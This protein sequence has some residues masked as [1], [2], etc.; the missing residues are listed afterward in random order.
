MKQQRQPNS[1]SS[2]SRV[3][4]VLLLTIA[5]P[6]LLFSRCSAD[7]SS[8][9]I[10]DRHAAT[11]TGLK[12]K[13]LQ[14]SLKKINQKSIRQ[15]TLSNLFEADAPLAAAAARGSKSS[16][17]APTAAPREVTPAHSTADPSLQ[18]SLTP[19]DS[20]RPSSK[21]SLAPSVS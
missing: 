5:L 12:E 4:T 15:R 8:S 10:I 6:Y 3:A 1:S 17:A 21:P 9:L 20:T 7:E 14:K 2:S 11:A 18:P 16:K 19:S 13:Q